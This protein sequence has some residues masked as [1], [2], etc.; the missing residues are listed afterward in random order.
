MNQVK[1]LSLLLRLLDLANLWN[2]FREPVKNYLA[3]FVRW[4]GKNDVFCIKQAQKLVQVDA[5]EILCNTVIFCS[6]LW[7]FAI[8]CNTL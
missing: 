4:G 6:T 8:L 3:D 2:P 7:Y 1:R 5:L